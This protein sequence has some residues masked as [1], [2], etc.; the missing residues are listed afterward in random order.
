VVV[1]SFNH[2]SYLRSCLESAMAQTYAPLELVVVDDGSSDGSREILQSY[3][4][5]ARVRVY[6]QEN[7]GSHA[8]I[9]RGIELARGR[10]IAI[11][12]SDDVFVPTRLAR[13][14]EFA[15]AQV[16]PCLWFTGVVAIDANGQPY[17]A[18]YHWNRMIGGMLAEWRR[19]PTRDDLLAYGNLAVSTSNFL[20][21]RDLLDLVGP[22]R[23]FRYV[24]D[25]EF[26]L[27]TARLGRQHWA[28]LEEPLLHY[29]LHGENTILTGVERSHLE[30]MRIVRQD[31]QLKAPH[32]ALALRRERY[33]T[34]NLRKYGNQQREIRAQK[35]LVEQHDRNAERLAQQAITLA[36]KEAQ[37][38]ELRHRVAQLLVENRKIGQSLREAT[39]RLEQYHADVVRAPIDVGYWRGQ[40]AQ[41]ESD[42]RHRPAHANQLRDVLMAAGATHSWRLT[43]PLRA[44]VDPGRRAVALLRHFAALVRRRGGIRAVVSG[45]VGVVRRED[46]SGLR[47]QHAATPE[48]AAESAEDLAL[49]SYE[50]GQPRP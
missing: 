2:A 34:N 48:P 3:A 42:A 5:D 44:A 41:F 29:R 10:F 22:L 26:L 21:R 27:R 11:L 6:L 16:Q 40:A 24:Q 1:P 15:E 47:E 36:G 20:F 31:L 25:W 12:N 49:A 32:L 30:A 43:V 19:D 33:L 4:G 39:A 23:K 8:A 14:M 9:N 50:R 7:A 13:L 17:P 35:Q 46:R 37:L 28:F 18:D 38:G 45:S